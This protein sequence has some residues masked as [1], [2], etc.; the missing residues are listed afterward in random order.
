M[1]DVCRP[2]LNEWAIFNE[3]Y[4]LNCCA[5][6]ANCFKALWQMS[7]VSNGVVNT[8]DE[9]CLWFVLR[10][11]KSHLVCTVE[12]VINIRW[13]LA[14]NSRQYFGVRKSTYI[15]WFICSLDATGHPSLHDSSDAHR[16]RLPGYKF[17]QEGAWPLA[18]DQ[19]LSRCALWSTHEAQ[20]TH[21]EGL[22]WELTSPLELKL[23]I[24]AIPAISCYFLQFPA[25]SCE[26]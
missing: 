6:Y 5:A 26:C 22:P 11:Y 8:V 13:A 14:Y 4:A 7:F 19:K 17:H 9:H 21:Y 23:A 12:G 3:F 1:N 25:I 16:S 2:D 24:L 10:A 18:S 15:P 20:G